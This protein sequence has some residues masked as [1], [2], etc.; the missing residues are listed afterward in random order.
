MVY[1]VKDIKTCVSAVVQLRIKAK[2]YLS[3]HFRKNSQQ[4]LSYLNRIQ[5]IDVHRVPTLRL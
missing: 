5:L 1:V 4:R 2:H 3:I